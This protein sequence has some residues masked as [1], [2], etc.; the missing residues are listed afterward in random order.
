MYMDIEY[1]K[2]KWRETLQDR[3]VDF[4]DF[5]EMLKGRFL[6]VPDTRKDYGEERWVLTGEVGGRLLVACYTMR[7]QTYRVFSMRKA[8]S[9]E[10]KRFKK[11]YR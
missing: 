3:D 1:D 6:R 8:N 7:G 2:A 9:R 5:P 11:L 4:R 10:Q